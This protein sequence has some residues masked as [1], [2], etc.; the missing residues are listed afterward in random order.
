[1]ERAYVVSGGL[2]TWVIAAD[3]AALFTWMLSLAP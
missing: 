1:M 2:S 3:A